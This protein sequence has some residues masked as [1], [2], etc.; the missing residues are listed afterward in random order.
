M[1]ISSCS[2]SEWAPVVV[3]PLQDGWTAM[4]CAC[5]EGHEHVVEALL[6]GGATVDIQD[7][8]TPV[9]IWQLV[10]LHSP[11]YSHT[12]VM[13]EIANNKCVHYWSTCKNVPLEFL[14]YLHVAIATTLWAQY[15]CNTSSLIRQDYFF[16]QATVVIP[17][18]VVLHSPPR[19][20][21]QL[22]C[23]HPLE[24]TFLLWRDFWQQGPSLTCRR[25][26]C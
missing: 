22:S 2:S 3:V 24:V 12:H 15:N 9:I 13:S 5:Q 19:L 26:Y 4:M 25:R 11:L 10:L 14:S 8:V 7:E 21:G 16:K 18:S 20:A 17:V 1:G 6:K 23:L